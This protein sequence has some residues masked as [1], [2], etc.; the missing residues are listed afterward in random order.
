MRKTIIGHRGRPRVASILARV[1]T[2]HMIEAS[3]IA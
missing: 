2:R 3:S 1:E